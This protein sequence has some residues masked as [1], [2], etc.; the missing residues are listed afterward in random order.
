MAKK[1][2]ANKRLLCSDCSHYEADPT[3][4]Y[5]D[6]TFDWTENSVTITTSM[7]NPTE[8]TVGFGLQYD[9]ECQWDNDDTWNNAMQSMAGT[10]GEVIVHNENDD[11]VFE[12]IAQLIS[13]RGHAE[14]QTLVSERFPTT[15]NITWK[16]GY[17]PEDEYWPEYVPTP[18]TSPYEH[19]ELTATFTVLAEPRSEW[20]EFEITKQVTVPEPP[21]PA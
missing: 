19:E 9:R 18:S 6:I 4:R 3:E 21:V 15:C 11:V 8:Y 10:I 1:K 12:G 14:Y 20:P 16:K 5:L 13:H 2:S 7:N 17:R